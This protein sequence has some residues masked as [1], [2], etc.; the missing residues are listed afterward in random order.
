MQNFEVG[1]QAMPTQPA[2]LQRL[3]DDVRLLVFGGQREC[4]EPEFDAHLVEALAMAASVRAVLVVLLNDSAGLSQDRRV[5]LARTGLLEAPTAVMTGSIRIRGMLTPINWLGGKVK[6][7][8]LHQFDEACDYLAV[9]G[10]ARGRLRDQMTA[11]RNE[12]AGE[13]GKGEDRASRSGTFAA[14]RRAVAAGFARVRKRGSG[15]GG[16]RW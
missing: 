2:L 8:T 12:L 4:T 3:V 13:P 15:E 7:F 1:Q 10:S 5:K 14:V 9:P 11:M 6:A 16:H